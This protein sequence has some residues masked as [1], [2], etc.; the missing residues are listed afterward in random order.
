MHVCFASTKMV[1]Y[2]LT[3]NGMS[4]YNQETLAEITLYVLWNFT[5]YM[6]NF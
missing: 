5:A 3:A 4:D 2:H 6:T 1:N